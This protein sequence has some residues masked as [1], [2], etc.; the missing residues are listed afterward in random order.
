[1]SQIATAAEE[2]TATTG[3]VTSNI[4]LITDVVHTTAKGAEQTAD[5]AAKLSQ[6]ALELQ[7]LVSRFKV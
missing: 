1:V 5:A 2:Q 4:Q 7:A 6:Q 3:E